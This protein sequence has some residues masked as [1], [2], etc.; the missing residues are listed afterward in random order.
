MGGIPAD[1]ERV[2]AEWF[3]EALGMRVD[4]A[5]VE[6]VTRQGRASRTYRAHLTSRA[7][8]SALPASVI[9]KCF[10][11]DPRVQKRRLGLGTY[12]LEVDFYQ[13]L[14]PS[15]AGLVPE[16]FHAQADDQTGRWLLVLEDLGQD[17]GDARRAHTDVPTAARAIARI[18]ARLW[19]DD[20]I[21]TLLDRCVLPGMLDQRRIGATERQIATDLLREKVEKRVLPE[22]LIAAA[23]AELDHHDRLAEHLRSRPFTCAHGDYHLRQVVFDRRAG[24]HASIIDWQTP[25]RA[26][27]A[28]DLQ[29]LVLLAGF[30][31]AERRAVEPEALSAYHQV[32]CTEGVTGYRLPELEHDYRLLLHHTLMWALMEGRSDDPAAVAL[33]RQTFVEPLE[34]ALVD[35]DYVELIESL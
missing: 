1:P 30:S 11:D 19:Q 13:Q 24:D 18:H 6:P 5:R 25:H 17:P 15:L 4:H 9:I 34:S 16:C 7:A 27:G 21:T 12:R 10:L 3:T 20:R 2:E 32:L 35:H 22:V 8:D 23:N 28:L 31:P 33:W 26:S 14:A 29:R